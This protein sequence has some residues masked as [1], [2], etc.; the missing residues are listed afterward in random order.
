[1][2]MIDG[3]AEEVDDFMRKMK[4]ERIIGKAIRVLDCPGRIKS[5][6]EDQSRTKCFVCTRAGIFS[7]QLKKRNGMIVVVTANEA[8]V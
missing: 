5:P 7:L 2:P 8:L 4:R 1:M 6:N 3:S